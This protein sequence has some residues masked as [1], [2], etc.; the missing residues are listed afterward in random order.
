[1][2]RSVLLVLALPLAALA[3]IQVSYIP[4]SGS[5]QVIP[6]A[7][8]ED[9]GTIAAG[10]T[11]SLHFQILNSGQN[12]TS[13]GT[14]N[15]NGFDFA[16]PDPPPLHYT[17]APG[18][19]LDFHVAF[20]PVQPNDY[21]ALLT[22]DSFSALLVG[23]AVAIPELADAT[24]ATWQA[25]DVIAFPKTQV[26]ASTAKSFSVVNPWSTPLTISTMTVSGDSFQ[27]TLPALPFTLPPNTTQAVQITFQPVA[28]GTNTGALSINGQP[29]G[30]TGDAFQP[31]LPPASLAISSGASASR[32][33][34]TI[35][36]QLASAAQSAGSG[37][38]TMSFVPSTPGA[39]DDPA[40]QFLDTG[41]RTENVQIANGAA[42]GQCGTGA[43]CTFQTGTTA[44]TITF[45]LS[46]GGQISQATL[47]VTPAV[48]SFDTASAKVVGNGIAVTLPGFD[49]T[50]ATTA[51]S[52]TF[53]DTSGKEIPSGVVVV[54][55]T[56]KFQQFFAQ[57]A[58]Q[59]GGLFQ[60]AAQF[61][62]TGTATQLGAVAVTA[63]NAAG[64]S[65][66]VQIPIGY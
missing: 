25:G 1:M 46:L 37:T 50:H 4:D 7:G 9:V 38:L 33:Q 29:F 52:F 13:I 40:I 63:T 42:A 22:I 43:A 28:S 19:T 66:S 39:S 44:G 45:T 62:V 20:A 27:A 56:A 35:A 47:V 48:V 11:A 55:V 32:Q 49:N 41:S 26:A 60:L 53:F 5:A 15:V 54:D 18:S 31:P 21:R 8:T 51:L 59:S 65:P 34:A 36:V 30:L 16:V 57:N 61:P 14:V 2:L 3:Q 6:V 12:A 10:T 24:G 17:L 23:H 64:T 58:P